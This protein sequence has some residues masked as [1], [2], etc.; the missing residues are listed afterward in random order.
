MQQKLLAV[1]I[2]VILIVAA[3]VLWVKSHPSA[4]LNNQATP[5]P[6]VIAST[7]PT[8]SQVLFPTSSDTLTEGQTYTLKWSG[9]PDPL[10]IFLVSQKLESQG[11]SVATVDKVYGVKNT[12]SYNYTVPTNLTPGSYKF[13]IGN[14]TSDYFQIASSNAQPSAT[15]TAT[16]YCT[17]SALDATLSLSGAA[18]NIYGT[19]AIK[20]TSNTPCQII[21]NNFM[22]VS[23]D[24]SIK[25]L[26]VTHT[27]TPTNQTFTIQPG[28]SIYS[29]VH[30]PNGPQCQGPTVQ[31]QVTFSYKISPSGSVTFKNTE[32]GN[33]AQIVQGCS[34]A[35]DMTEITVWNM[36]SQP[37]TPQ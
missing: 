12:G 23:Y 30:Y 35:T 29:Q 14:L 13:E 11:Q 32:N 26:T 33:T 18:G 28:K 22:D 3:V 25:N 5:I 7:S 31:D 19:A 20:N 2:I 17:P 27:G 36:S 16:S 4:V 21:G 10:Q 6:S 8:R 9:G 34:S 24:S 15:S 37:I 1:F